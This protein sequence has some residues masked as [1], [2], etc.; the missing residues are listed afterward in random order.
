M[1]P[2][3]LTPL[4]QPCRARVPSEIEAPTMPDCVPTLP[5]TMGAPLAAAPPP[6]GPPAAVADPVALARPAEPALPA[7]PPTPDAPA[8]C[9]AAAEVASPPPAVPAA[10]G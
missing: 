4:A 8:A 7:E 5:M 2:W 9:W 6:A 10:A 3:A 1:P